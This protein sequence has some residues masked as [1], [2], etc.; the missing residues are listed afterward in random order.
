MLLLLNEQSSCEE[1]NTHEGV[2]EGSR[3][4]TEV[5]A[6]PILSPGLSEEAHAVN[7]SSV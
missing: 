5:E 6:K 1:K 2:G 4:P 3:R 7:I